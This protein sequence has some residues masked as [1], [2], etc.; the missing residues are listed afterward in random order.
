MR[1]IVTGASGVLGRATVAALHGQGHD[2]AAIDRAADPDL[3]AGI[4]AIEC[5]DLAGPEQARRAIDAAVYALGGLESLVQLTG[6]FAWLPVT[7]STID[8]WRALYAQNVETTLV[9]IQASLPHLD[10]GG[11]IVCVG[12]ASA[13]PAGAGMAPYAAS[14]SAVARLVEALSQELSDRAIRIN[15]VLPRIIDTPRNRA[16]MPSADPADWTRPEAIADVVAFLVSPAARAV[17][18]ALLPVTNR[19]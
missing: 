18:G 19:S 12:A 16:D 8:D 17:N 13:E 11:A 10:D 1:I 2:I 6:G 3:P 9:T 5:A 15:A 7:K 14:K 4:H